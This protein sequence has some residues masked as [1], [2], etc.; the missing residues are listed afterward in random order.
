MTF[1]NKNMRN[2]V[3]SHCNNAKLSK[4]L[5]LNNR[6]DFREYIGKYLK[7]RK[8]TLFIQF[9]K[10]VRELSELSELNK[11]YKNCDFKKKINIEMIIWCDKFTY[12]DFIFTRNLPDLMAIIGNLSI[13]KWIYKNKYE[14]IRYVFEGRFEYVSYYASQGGYLNI[15]KWLKKKDVSINSAMSISAKE[16]HLHIIKWYIKKNR[17]SLNQLVNS[18]INAPFGKNIKIIKMLYKIINIIPNKHQ[19]EYIFYRALTSASI[20]GHLHIVKWIYNQYYIS[21]EKYMDISETKQI[22]DAA[23]NGH[24]DIVKYLLEKNNKN[25]FTRTALETVIKNRHIDIVILLQKYIHL[26]DEFN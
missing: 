4:I 2:H 10:R 26:V 14:L 9:Q 8:Y 6:D 17:L 22:D 25:S 16:G 19:L 3:I 11:K 20:I 12:F 1:L 15:L 5:Q 13:L 24:Y 23:I 21:Y 18:F 7:F